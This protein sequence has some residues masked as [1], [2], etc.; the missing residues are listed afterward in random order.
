[1]DLEK[2]IK[3]SKHLN[4]STKNI[5]HLKA[6]GVIFSIFGAGLF[7]YFIHSVGLN[8]ILA[9]IAKI[10][11]GGFA[12]ILLI[13]FLKLAVRAMAWRLSVYEPH[14][15]DFK[16]TL[17]AVIIGEALS[18]IIPLGILI[19]GTA[20][21]IAVRRR[22]P[23]V[24][25]LASIA[26]EN[27]F[28]SLITG[29]FICFGAFVFLRQFQLDPS[30]IYLIDF[31]IGFIII[32][33]IIG[34]LMVVRQWHWASNLCH[35][36]YN[37]YFLRS[38]LEKGR[39]QVRQFEDLIYGFYHKY[40][41]R[42]FPL[43]LLQIVFHSLGIFEAWFILTRISELFPQISTA[44]FL[45]SMSRLITIVF[46]LIPFLVGVDEAGAEFIIETLAIGTGIGVTLAII[47]KGR[48]I[49]W[50]AIGLILIIK[51]GVSFKEI[52]EI[53]ETENG[54]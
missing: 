8:E 51:R 11:F 35:W 34:V 26:T 13:Y 9:G 49:F 2:N 29:L 43:C 3:N 50:T 44:F 7:L 5:K 36:L 42:F 53:G 14:K 41:Q 24:V 37:R 47:R 17:P 40:P 15:L 4:G 28:Y 6:L 22:V 12:I 25:G 31:V 33:I 27:L 23:L 39:G 32:C 10:G 21:A 45:E 54:L 38:I 46:K 16:D 18:N 19:S 48:T 1:M 52:K 20:K 30:Y